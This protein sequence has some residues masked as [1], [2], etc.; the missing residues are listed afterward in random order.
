MISSK[1][2]LL[3]DVTHAERLRQAEHAQLVQEAVSA[4]RRPVAADRWW[5]RVW[6]R[7][8]GPAAMPV[9]ELAATQI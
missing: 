7:D 6:R 5:R 1:D 9:P 8:R 3:A 4:G 2:L